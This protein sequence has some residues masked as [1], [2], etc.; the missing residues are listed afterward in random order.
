LAAGEL[1]LPR[2]GTPLLDA[3]LQRAKSSGV[4]SV[5]SDGEVIYADGRFTKV[6]RDAALRALHEDLNKA[7]ADDE[8]ERRK[9]SKALLPHVK[10]FFYAEDFDPSA[11][12]PFYRPVRASEEGFGTEVSGDGAGVRCGQRWQSVDRTPGQDVNALVGAG[13]DIDRLAARFPIEDVGLNVVGTG[14]PAKLVAL[15]CRSLRPN[16]SCAIAA[17][18]RQRPSGLPA[19]L[20]TVARL[21]IV[22]LLTRANPHPSTASRGAAQQRDKRQ[23]LLTGR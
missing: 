6:D 11:H 19:R 3:V 13:Q 20:N 17:L 9:L 1:A 5:I 12:A 15:D 23:Q 10:A 7:L 21:K 22:A 4:H 14:V 8:V 2:C 16:A 18:A